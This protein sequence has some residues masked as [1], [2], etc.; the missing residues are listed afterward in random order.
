M[1]EKPKRKGPLDAVPSSI[2]EWAVYDVP[3]EVIEA[4]KIDAL[5]TSGINANTFT[6]PVRSH[7][8]KPPVCGLA[9]NYTC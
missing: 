4:F 5:K 9:F 3:D 2:E 6:K 7:Q 8:F 1:R